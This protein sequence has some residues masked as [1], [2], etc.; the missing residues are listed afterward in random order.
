MTKINHFL[1]DV[2]IRL[3]QSGMILKCASKM[4]KMRGRR[5]TCRISY[6]MLCYHGINVK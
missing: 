4:V 2:K 6:E 3:A 5:T 1:M